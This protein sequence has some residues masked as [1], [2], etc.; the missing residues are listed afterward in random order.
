[1]WRPCSASLLLCLRDWRLQLK[2]K[3]KGGGW[4]GRD[5]EPERGSVGVI[6]GW[7][8]LSKAV[9]EKKEVTS[10]PHFFHTFCPQIMSDYRRCCSV[11]ARSANFCCTLTPSRH[12]QLLISP[13]YSTNGYEG[14][15]YVLQ[16]S[17]SGSWSIDEFKQLWPTLVC[18][19]ILLACQ[20]LSVVLAHRFPFW[21]HKTGHKFVLLICKMDQI[22]S[23]NC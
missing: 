7:N 13:S 10:L 6:H 4:T 18:F 5:S 17:T 21:G 3:W 15:L 8:K 9:G 12:L 22:I 16:T 14:Q 2:K 23:L 19:S 20:L 11:T 1:M